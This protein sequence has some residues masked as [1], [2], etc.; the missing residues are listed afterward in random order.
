MTQLTGLTGLT[1]GAVLPDGSGD[2]FVGWTGADAWARLRDAATTFDAL[3]YDHLWTSDHLMASGGD[4]SGPYFEGY[5]TLA[6]LTQVT[7]RARL[8]ALVTCA[9]YRNAGLLAKQAAS[10]DLMSGGRLIFALGGGW[11]SDEFAAYGYDFP[12][13]AGRVTAFEETLDAVLRLWSEPVVDLDGSYVRLRGARCE[14]KPATRPPIWT[15]THGPRGLRAAARY[16][17]VANWNVELDEFRRLSGVL[18]KACASVGRDPATIDRSVFRLADLTGND[19]A[20][21]RLLA[22]QGAPP[23][24]VDIVREE[25]F[26]GTPEEVVPKVQAFVDAGARHVIVMFLDAESSDE[27]ATRFLQEVVPQVAV[28]T[29]DSRE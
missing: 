9:L 27:S 18:A 11:D 22:S 13:P 23:D 10:V 25:H 17:D 16:A 3:G 14:P 29:G 28:T 15:G 24:A 1:W 4:R 12:P 19:D 5:G 6:A 26:V 20:V 8:G 21:R 2:E 7:R